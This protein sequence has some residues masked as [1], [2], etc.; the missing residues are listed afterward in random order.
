MPGFKNRITLSFIAIF[1][2]A[3]VWE[4]W[5]RPKTSPLYT[6]AVV[7]YRAG[8]YQHSLKLLIFAYRID[9]ND[10]AVLS[11]LGWN[12]LKMND[13]AHGEPY[14]R[15][16]HTLAPNVTDLLLGYAYTE[17]ALDKY[18]EAS[19]L[20]KILSN[21]GVNTVDVHIAWATL[22]RGRGQYRDSVREFQRAL[23]IDPSSELAARN[24]R[25]IL[26]TTGD[27]SQFR[28][29]DHPQ[30]RPAQLALAARVEGDHFAWLEPH[31]WQPTYLVGVNLT[32]SLPGHFPADPVTDPAIYDDWLI[33]ISD[34][35]TN[36]LRIST[37]LPAA[38]YRSLS[39]FNNNSGRTPLRLL[40]GIPLGDAQGDDFLNRD[41]EATC[42]KEIRDTVDA[43]HGQA[44]LA[45]T[46]NHSGGVF[47]NNV[48]PWIAGFL[49][50]QA[51]T[52]HSV[53]S[54]NQIHSDLRSFHGKYVEVP[55]GSA[56]E[57]F[58]AQ[59]IDYAAEYEET[60]YNWQHPIGSVNLPIFDPMR[61][62]TDSTFY[63]EVSLRRA[64]GERFP[65]PAGPHDDDDAVTIDSMHLRPLPR[66]QAGYF[67]AYSVFP[68]YPD[69]ITRESK[70]S[71]TIDS[72][73]N[74]PFLGYIRDLK[75]HHPG[76]PLVISEYGVPSSLGIGHF[77]GAGFDQ[78]GATEAQQGQALSR[79]THNIFDAGAAG[80][81]VFEWV[82][83][84]SR[85]N[86]IVRNF[87]VPE[88]RKAL[89]PNFMDPAED[90]GV[91]AA[92]PHLSSIHQLEGTSLEWANTPPLYS[93]TRPGL[94]RREGDPFDAARH[95]KALYADADE[96]FLYLRLVVEKLDNDNDGQPEWNNVNYLIGIST[97][98]GQAGLTHLPFIAPIR[99]PMG[100]TYAI[101]L[102]SR[103]SSRIWIASNYNPYQIV[104][105]E[106]MPGQTTLSLK[107]GWQARVSEAGT[108]ESQVIEPN[109]RRFGRNREV[110]PPQR[111]DRGI[112][113]YGSLDSQSPDFDSLAEWHANVRTNTIDLRIP[114]NL[115]N[116]TD[117]SSLKVF[118]G[119]D[120]DGTVRIADTPGFLMAVFSYRP[121]E[122]SRVR[123]IMDQRHPVAD[124]LPGM[125]REGIVSAAPYKYF[126]W[127]KWDVPQYVLRPKHSYAILRQAFLTLQ[128]LHAAGA[129]ASEQIT[130]SLPPVGVQTVP[131]TKELNQKNQG[132]SPTPKEAAREDRKP[133]R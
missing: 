50:S 131:S 125:S 24:L 118:A 94:V 92:E 13:P 75:A 89:W 116:V 66:F 122:A 71:A 106:S 30:E 56:S 27:V 121:E 31:G 41:Y 5:I 133:K 68:Y 102:S 62:I 88:D 129:G 109:R 124:V 86:W 11:L 2:V 105:V 77:A 95:L 65:I 44:D 98:P 33:K 87:E 115:L 51:W 21:K 4:F 73:G 119:T 96:G 12:Y 101:Q 113:R 17:I 103:D 55:S 112:L 22:F 120:H 59:M 60:K 76:I 6:E 47:T 54:N 25:E 80:G 9:P 99:F 63:E 36:T 84:W 90:F 69:F 132:H 34:L 126:L 128:P 28:M 46:P 70:Y 100:M 93:E 35:G 45:Q 111:Y 23:A 53:I 37:I 20:L 130:Q 97:A 49:L 29:D 108:F 10:S 48:A 57:V 123:P 7:Q 61:H 19:G 8:N 82:D 16:A 67:A 14:F 72:E 91:L 85:R 114:W 43:I 39:H 107:L 15:R 58:L 42:Q 117:P 74:N 127:K 40:Q 79:M 26:N 18:N 78:G 110:F 1:C 3:L 64:E 32:P 104:P 52:S 81:M 38:F 83:E